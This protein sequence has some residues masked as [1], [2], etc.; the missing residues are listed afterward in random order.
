MEWHDEVGI[1]KRWQGECEPLYRRSEGLE[2]RFFILKSVMFETAYSTV[3]AGMQKP[4][5]RWH[6]A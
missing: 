5:Y 4:G 1:V 2:E 6:P 3:A